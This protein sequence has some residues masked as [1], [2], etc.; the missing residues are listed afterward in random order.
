M[1][2][3][4]RA[5]VALAT[6]LLFIGSTA[7]PAWAHEEINPKTFSTQT[8]TFFTLSAADEQKVDLVRV[9]LTAPAGVP[10]GDT[11]KEPPQWTSEKTETAVTWT[12]GSGAGVKPDKFDT[13]GFETDGADQ[14]GTFTFK[15]TLG[16]ADGHTDDVSVPVTAVAGAT[17]PTTT[18]VSVPTA[19]NGQTA[20]G[21]AVKSVRTRANTGIALGVVA[22][23]LALLALLAAL[24]RRPAPAPARS[25]DRP[26]EDW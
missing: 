14:P 6:G 15:I 12:A 25:G 23:V 22:A 13:W 7:L 16:F 24:L 9:V 17:T 26:D 1:N 11:T 3:A 20:S 2:P 18:S 4:R 21:R 19:S 8:P 5:L 10:L